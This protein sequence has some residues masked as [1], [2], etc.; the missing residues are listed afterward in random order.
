[1]KPNKGMECKKRKRSKHVERYCML[2]KERKK[3]RKKEI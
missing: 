1:M 3:E 2:K